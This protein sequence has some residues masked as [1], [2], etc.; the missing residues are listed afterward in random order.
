MSKVD[1]VVVGAG[2]AG[3][4]CARA[5]RRVGLD[6][7]VVDASDA[8]GGRVRTDEFEGF[9]L[10]RGFQ[11]LLTAYPEATAQ[12]DYPSLHL[13][14]FRAGARVH[15]PDGWASVGDPTRDAGETLA[16]LAAPI[17]SLA[18][19][20]RILRYRTRVRMGTHDD[21]LRDAGPAI[22]ETLRSREGF[23]ATMVNRFFRPFLG[24]VFLDPD[25]RTRHGVADWLWRL[26]SEGDAAVPALGI[27]QLP[28]QLANGLPGGALRLGRIVTAVTPTSVT[29]DDGQTIRARAVVLAVDQDQAATLLRQPALTRPWTAGT[30][31]YFTAPEDPVGDAILVL[32]GDG[33]GP[34]NNMHSVSALQPD[35]APP[36]ETLLS[37]TVIG[38]PPATDADLN[39]LA[40]DVRSHLGEWYGD[41]TRHWR[42]LRAYRIPQAQPEQRPRSH[43]AVQRASGG[44]AVRLEGA[45]QP[46]F[47]CG[48][49][50][51]TSS[52]NG[53][54]LSGR[55][56]AQQ[57]MELLGGRSAAS[58]EASRASA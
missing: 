23:S 53:A 28:L 51:E 50:L 54:M 8:P 25:L 40:A 27:G 36:G 29:L 16:T 34:V 4:T 19:K 46:V 55:K 45:T 35:A 44:G 21:V 38:R 15:T 30:C 11:V 48:D 17:G 2:L 49:Y 7:V 9:L 5:L 24:G 31:L 26:F 3:L 42:L 10:D 52:F 37:A 39:R 43:D 32:N 41:R 1:V 13:R 12:L 33:R 14:R 18:D 47:V 6:V 57:V 58:D 20:V 22:G 56:A